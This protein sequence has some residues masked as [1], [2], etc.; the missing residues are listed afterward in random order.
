MPVI[1]L[2]LAC[3]LAA[4]YSATSQILSGRV[5]DLPAFSGRR[6]IFSQIIIALMV[7]VPLQWVVRVGA[8]AFMIR[9][10]ATALYSGNPDMADLWTARAEKVAPPDYFHVPQYRVLAGLARL[11]AAGNQMSVDQRGEIITKG[12]RDLAVVDEYNKAP[13][14]TAQE[15]AALYVHAQD[16]G[17]MLDGYARAIDEFRQAVQ[18]N[19]RN[20]AARMMLASIL[21]RRGEVA[22]AKEMLEEGLSWPAASEAEEVNYMI[23]VAEIRQ[24]VGDDAGAQDILRRAADKA[25]AAGLIRN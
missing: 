16:A 6:A 14:F 21:S 15:R 10:A 11:K 24:T 22:A 13:A 19:P 9:N 12:L 18:A 7:L 25:Q 2:P 20:F 5:I 17:L 4:W 1:L 3:L 23:A 8:G